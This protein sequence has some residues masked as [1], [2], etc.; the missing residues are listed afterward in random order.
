MGGTEYLIGHRVDGNAQPARPTLA[1]G[2]GTG[3]RGVLFVGMLVEGHAGHAD[4]ANS[5]GDAVVDL[6]DQRRPTV[7]E[8]LDEGELPQ[9]TGT[10][11]GGHRDRAGDVEHGLQVTRRWRHRPAEVVAEIEA[12]VLNPAR[13]AETP[14]RLCHLLAQAGYLPADVLDSSPQP[15]PVRGL[16]EDGNAD[17]RGAQARITLDA[18]QGGVGLVH[19]TVETLVHVVV[20]LWPS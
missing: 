14:R 20:L 7:G 6:L 12:G 16:A 3:H 4:R 1:T 19:A 2:K 15:L 13:C 9:G 8:T 11:E 17:D 10:V 5:V 18:P